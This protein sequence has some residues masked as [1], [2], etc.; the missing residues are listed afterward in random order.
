MK[1]IAISEGTWEKL[2]RIREEEKLENFNELIEELI[3]KSKKVPH[4]MF[5]VDKHSKSYT[6][7]EHAKFQSDFHG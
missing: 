2:K 5:G 7:K 3:N 6:Y 4:S 1:T